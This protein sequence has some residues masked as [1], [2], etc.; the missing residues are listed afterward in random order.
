MENPFRRKADNKEVSENTIELESLPQNVRRAYEELD[1]KKFGG[2]DDLG[3]FGLNHISTNDLG[4]GQV[5]Y[6]FQGT[7]K[8]RV[9]DAEDDRAKTMVEKDATIKVTAQA[10]EVTSTEII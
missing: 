5:E 2:A 4:D 8:R 10:G 9:G 1:R 6:L 3:L 7:L